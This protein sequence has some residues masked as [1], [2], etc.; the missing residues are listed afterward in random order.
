MTE[1]EPPKTK[2]KNKRAQ[3]QEN[4]FLDAD[5]IEQD[6]QKADVEA[7]VEEAQT[8][9]RRSKKNGKNGAEEKEPP[10]KESTT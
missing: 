6:G 1:E 4:D 7:K 2:T 8:K 3:T 9:V 10:R 5:Q